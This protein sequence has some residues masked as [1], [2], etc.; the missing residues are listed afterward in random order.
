M[1]RDGQARVVL[2]VKQL[3]LKMPRNVLNAQTVARRCQRGGAARVLQPERGADA[4]RLADSVEL[5]FSLTR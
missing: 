3:E 4:S 1:R 5:A 2:A